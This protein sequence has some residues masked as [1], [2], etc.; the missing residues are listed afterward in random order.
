MKRLAV[1]TDLSPRA[2][3]AM[4]RAFLLADYLKLPLMVYSVIDDHLPEDMGASQA[5][6]TEAKLNQFCQSQRGSETVDWTVE[7]LRGSIDDALTQACEAAG[8]DLMILGLHRQRP[9]MDL[10]RE[11][12]MERLVRRAGRPVLIARD[13]ADHPYKSVLGAVDFA[14]ASTTALLVAAKLCEAPDMRAVHAVHVPYHGAVAAPGFVA[15]LPPIPD[16]GPFLNEAR[17]Q[18]EK[19]R[20]GYPDLAGLDVSVVEGSLPSVLHNAMAESRPDV[21]AIGTHSRAVPMPWLLG[22]CVNDLMREPPCDLLVVPP[23][24]G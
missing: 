7:V 10:I 17:T 21:L 23:E 12:T 9:L 14:P 6:Q 3:R 11:T 20:S 1:A 8:I 2:D 18:L 4:A 19:W 16:A 15:E 24:A 13:R 22:S 5:A